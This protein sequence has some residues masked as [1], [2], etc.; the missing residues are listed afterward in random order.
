M[1]ILL[2]TN[3][4]IYREANYTPRREIGVL[5]RWLDKLHYEK[6]IHPDT[7]AEIRRHE[8][9]SVV[10][11]FEAK[12]TNYH[13]LKTLAPENDDIRSVRTRYDK[14][15]NDHTGTSILNE[16]FCNRVS[17]LITE[18]RRIHRKAAD[19]GIPERVF[20]I[21]SF[22]EKVTAENPELSDYRIL[23]V[24]KEYFG[25][26]DIRD[27]FFDS[28]KDD[29]AEF[30]EWFNRKSDEFAYVCKSDEGEIVAFLYV[31]PE[32]KD[33]NYADIAPPLSPAKRLKIGTF[34]IISN[35][36]KLGERFLKIIFDNA[37]RFSVDEIYV[38]LFNYTLEQHRLAALLGDW[39]FESYGIK[40]T[41]NGEEV[42][43]VR[44]FRPSVNK[45]NPCLSYPFIS[46]DARKYIV[47]IYPKYHTELFPDSIL[48]TES[49]VNFVENKPNRNAI[50]K[51]YISRSIE[52]NLEAGDVIVFYR[53][54][55]G[56][57]A[58]Y[59]SVATTIGVVQNI[60]TA[61]QSEA[62]FI[63]LC[64]KRSVFSDQELK[65]HWNYWPN[66]RPFIVNF[67]Y[68]HTFP[69]RMNLK[70]LIDAG[71][72]NSTDEVPRGFEQITDKQFQSIMEGSNADQRL[73]VN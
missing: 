57:S 67:L 72:I 19:L 20:T 58:Y 46:R 55:S 71:V 30:D 60:I 39:G 18:D 48:K 33:E 35:G 8:D 32:G 47:P 13:A 24:K 56:G 1:R 14:D 68:V 50:S 31:K 2:D 3:I 5:F 52:R 51:V 49:S 70:A 41:N 23:S 61:I 22:L 44:D 73:I 12:I 54:A 28:F 59:T 45:V 29:Y 17:A 26:L 6:C 65:G 7:I 21:D 62:Q 4:V 16:V 43:L 40:R 69:N 42:V 66:N 25:N 15:L 37:L 11:A 38:T 27:S 63:E 53:T 64:R 34:K 36:Y 10:D 9:K